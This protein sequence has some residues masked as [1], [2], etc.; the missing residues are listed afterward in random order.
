[1]KMEK[2]REVKLEFRDKNEEVKKWNR[3]NN[4]KLINAR[5]TLAGNLELRKQKV[6]AWIHIVRVGMFYSKTVPACGPEKVLAASLTVQSCMCW[7]WSWFA[8]LHGLTFHLACSKAEFCQHWDLV[9]GLGSEREVNQDTYSCIQKCTLTTDKQITVRLEDHL[10]KMV[11]SQKKFH[12][13]RI[14]S[15]GYRAYAC[16]VNDTC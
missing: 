14:K 11:L 13:N 1:M 9:Q 3:W 12:S 5:K 2:I 4:K 7:W 8:R 10:V 6:D 15:L 16:Q